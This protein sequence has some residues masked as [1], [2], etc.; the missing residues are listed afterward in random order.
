MKL[1]L[2]VFGGVEANLAEFRDQIPGPPVNVVFL[3]DLAHALHA[4]LLLFRLHLQGHPDGV[5]GLVDV[6]RV[7]QQ[8]IAQF[9][10]RP[11]E[12]AQDQHAAFVLARGQKFFRYQVH[13][14]VQRGHQTKI[15]GSIV[16]SDLLVT[17]LSFQEDDGFP[18][19]G[20]EAPI[21][22]FRLSLHLRKQIVVALDVSAAGGANLHEREFSLVAGR[23]LQEPFNCQ[24]TFENAFCVVDAVHADTKIRRLHAQGAQESRAFEVGRAIGRVLCGVIFRQIHADGKRPD[25][26]AVIAAQNGK[27]FP[28][29][30]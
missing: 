3:D 4:Q 19:A 2:L 6:I 25:H 12:L 1:F 26:G 18:L 28:I 23:L 24:K 16:R 8:R 5:G 27:V 21:D 14:V 9:A 7:H 13:A 11:G 22:P 10:G 30:S 29:H 20:L 17:V 15:G